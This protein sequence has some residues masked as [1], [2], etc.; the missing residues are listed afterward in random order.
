MNRRAFVRL[1][2]LPALAAQSNKS[3]AASQMKLGTQHGSTNEI[4]RVLAALG[5]TH[6]CSTLPSAKFDESWSVEG[7]TKLRERVNSFG[8]ALAAVPLPLSSHPIAKAE[9]PHIMLGKSPERDAEIDAIC[10]MIRNSARAGIPMLKYNLTILGVV[11]SGTSTGRGGARYSTFVYDQAK[12]DPPLTEAGPVSEEMMWDR[13]TYFLKRV[14]PVAEE[15]GCR[16]KSLPPH[17]KKQA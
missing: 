1:A 3:P 13:I 16:L 6:I 12:Q 8:I 4:L 10:Q 11:R 7:L 2:G 15:Y 17:I 14:I 9:N 5:V